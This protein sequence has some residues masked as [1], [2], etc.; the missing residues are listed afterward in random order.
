MKKYFII[1][2]GLIL[3]AF[4]FQSCGPTDA[5]IQG[6][7]KQVLLMNAPGT[8]CTVRNGIVTIEGTVESDEMKTLIEEKVKEL[9]GVKRIHNDVSVVPPAPKITPDETMRAAVIYALEAA[10][11]K[12]VEV[13]VADK[14]VTLKGKYNKADQKKILAI[15]NTI[16]ASKIV[17]E[18]TVK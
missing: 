9:D 3:A 8:N 17:N 1:C 12:D 2:L 15:A 16:D 5:E 4:T 11:F 14:V 18:M 7:A 13:T 6:N 10:N